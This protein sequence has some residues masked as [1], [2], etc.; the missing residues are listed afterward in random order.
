MIGVANS[1]AAI[2]YNNSQTVWLLIHEQHRPPAKPQRLAQKQPHLGR[3]A[4]DAGESLDPVAL[5]QMNKG[6]NL[7][8]GGPAEAMRNFRRHGLRIYGTFIFGYDHDTP[9]TFRQT[10]DFAK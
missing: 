5:K 3:L 10:M 7:M 8:R 2:L 6:F 9:E 4:T 1:N